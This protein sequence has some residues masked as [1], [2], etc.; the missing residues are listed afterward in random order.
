MIRVLFVC[1]G[2]IC[3]SPTAHGLFRDLV[4]KEELSDSIEIDSAGTHAY[5]IGNKPDNRS[6]M[7]AEKRGVDLSDLTARQVKLNDFSHYDYIL[8]M[9]QSNLRDLFDI[10]PEESQEKISLLSKFSKNSDLKDVPD[11]YYGGPNGFEEVFDQILDS[12][13][14][15]LSVIKKK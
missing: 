12:L 7:G 14:G 3:R 8:A 1:M 6:Q 2:N 4:D 9:D 15:L 13:E 10:C 11:P 5:H